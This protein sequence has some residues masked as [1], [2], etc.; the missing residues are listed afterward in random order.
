M[1]PAQSVKSGFVWRLFA[2]VLAP[3]V[4]VSADLLRINWLYHGSGSHSTTMSFI[5][6]IAAGGWFVLTLPIWR[7]ARVACLLLYIPLAWALLIPY[8][9]WFIAVVFHGMVSGG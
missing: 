4:I 8:S 1:E 2:A 3:I 7:I 5:I 9:L 6:G